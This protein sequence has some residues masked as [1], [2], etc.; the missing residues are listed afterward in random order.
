MFRRDATAI[1][2]AAAASPEATAQVII[3]AVLTANAG[4]GMAVKAARWVQD[5]V[6]TLPASYHDIPD[7]DRS[8]MAAAMSGA[9]LQAAREI[10]AN[11]HEIYA[12]R[13]SMDAMDFW[14]YA[15]DNVRGLGMVKAAFVVQMLYNEMGCIDAHNIRMMGYDKVMLTGKSKVRR[16]NYLSL[17][18]VKTSQA[19]WD[20]WCD[21]VA[22]RYPKQFTSGDEV[23]RLHTV[24]VLGE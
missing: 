10:W 19:W 8:V 21:F 18:S 5:N 12:K 1:R 2:N 22:K 9:K 13:E 14:H 24:A 7:S 15:I 16:Q 6:D 11:R 17:Q 3:F 20:D 4:F 23:S